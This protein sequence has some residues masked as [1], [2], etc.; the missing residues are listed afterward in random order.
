MEGHRMNRRSLLG[1]LAVLAIL[2]SPASA[3]CFKWM[4]DANGNGACVQ[5]DLVNRSPF[6]YDV[7][8]SSALRSING[9]V[10][11]G[12]PPRSC[13]PDEEVV[14]RSSGHFACAKNVR[15]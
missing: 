15:E 10:T 8:P 9:A 11:S 1:A 2:A 12:V 7:A 6:I 5:D 13:N 14:M 4:Y 3:E